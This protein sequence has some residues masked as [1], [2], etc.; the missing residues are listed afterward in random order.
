MK[1][2]KNKTNSFVNHDNWFFSKNYS[3]MTNARCVIFRRNLNWMFL[4]FGIF[5]KRISIK[6]F[7]TCKDHVP[8][9]SFLQDFISNTNT[10]RYSRMSVSTTHFEKYPVLLLTNEK[11]VYCLLIY[12][13]LL[14]IHWSFS[15]IVANQTPY[16]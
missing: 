14:L 3:K 15:L 8:F 5:I 12:S 16:L 6:H 11:D 13:F 1:Q 10:A 4:R 7:T 2:F 9:L